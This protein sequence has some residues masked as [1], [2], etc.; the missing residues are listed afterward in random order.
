LK[1]Y[2]DTVSVGSIVMVNQADENRGMSLVRVLKLKMDKT[3]GKKN[4]K[5]DV[6]D[7]SLG[8]ISSNS[9]A[10]IPGKSNAMAGKM[11]GRK[12]AKVK[13]DKKKKKEIV[14][15]EVRAIQTFFKRSGQTTPTP[16]VVEGPFKKGTPVR[17]EKLEGEWALVVVM[18]RSRGRAGIEGWVRTNILSPEV[19]P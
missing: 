2:N 1:T 3:T 17:I 18:D 14:K 10:I 15:M 9:L 13:S 6:K 7:N 19:V 8:W 5:S 11:G 16:F 4:T 12:D